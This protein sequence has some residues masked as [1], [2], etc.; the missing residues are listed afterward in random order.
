MIDNLPHLIADMDRRR[1]NKMLSEL[2]STGKKHSYSK[3]DLPKAQKKKPSRFAIDGNS[4]WSIIDERKLEVTEKPD[5]AFKTMCPSYNSV[6]FF[7]TRGRSDK[8][9]NNN[10]AI[11]IID[12]QGQK[13]AGCCG[14]WGRKT[15]GYPILVFW[16]F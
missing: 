14:G 11:E 3:V 15:P 16:G 10:S 1:H 6:L 7:D 12:K 13:Y 9:P 5:P 2:E 8:F 4:D